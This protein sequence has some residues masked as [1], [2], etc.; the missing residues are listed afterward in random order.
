MLKLR[1]TRSNRAAM[2]AAIKLEIIEDGVRRSIH[3]WVG[4]GGS[5]GASPLR[6]HIGV[7]DATKIERIEIYWPTTGDRQVFEHVAVDRFYEIT[8]GS[9]DLRT[10]E[11]RSFKFART[12]APDHPHPSH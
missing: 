5:F 7:G 2:G 3:R 11:Y 9:E 8:E 1:G 6:Q 4:S 12:G 10:L